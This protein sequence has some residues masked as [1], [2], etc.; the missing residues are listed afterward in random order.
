VESIIKSNKPDDG[1]DGINTNFNKQLKE[2]SF[3]Y[4]DADKD[5]KEFHDLLM[6]DIYN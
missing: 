5:I 3:M 2:L 6:K 4:K 1:D